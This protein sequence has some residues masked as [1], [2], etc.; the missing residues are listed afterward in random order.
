M[1]ARARHVSLL[2]FFLFYVRINVTQVVT[3]VLYTLFPYKNTNSN[4]YHHILHIGL[5]Y[6]HFNTYCI[7]F[8]IV[9][10]GTYYTLL[11]KENKQLRY[12]TY[13]F[14]KY[15]IVKKKKKNIPLGMS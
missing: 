6:S 15:L 8:N 2:C 1:R 14:I 3:D 9:G 12:I 4:T 7:L 13:K 11:C 10:L 5:G